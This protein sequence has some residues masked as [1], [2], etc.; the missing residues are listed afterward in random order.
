MVLWR[1]ASVLHRLLLQAL[2]RGALTEAVLW[3][4]DAGH[5]LIVSAAGRGASAEELQQ[6]WCCGNLLT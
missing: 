5:D 4:T 3:R 1:R 6:R 2:G